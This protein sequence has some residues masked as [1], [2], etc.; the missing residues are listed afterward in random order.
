MNK[1]KMKKIMMNKMKNHKNKKYNCF[2]IKLIND[3][4]VI[5]NIL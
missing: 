2:F 5:F 3:I 1:K 4:N